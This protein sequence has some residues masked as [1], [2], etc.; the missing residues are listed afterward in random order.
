MVAVGVVMRR[1]GIV[2]M[3]VLDD[4]VARTTVGVSTLT[5][6]RVAEAERLP[7]HHEECHENRDGGREPAHEPGL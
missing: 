1:I 4:G 5:A 2:V 3:V 7:Q 6:T